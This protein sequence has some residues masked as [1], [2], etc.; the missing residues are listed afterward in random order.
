[1]VL[2]A[3]AGAKHALVTN[4]LTSEQGTGPVRAFYYSLLFERAT[5]ERDGLWSGGDDLRR[6]VP[7]CAHGLPATPG[8]S[9]MPR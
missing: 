9:A 3:V 4:V 7:S 6:R 5:H 2:A 8:S 1:M